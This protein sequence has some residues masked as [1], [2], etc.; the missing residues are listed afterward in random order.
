MAT[1]V[2]LTTTLE[3]SRNSVVRAEP[4]FSRLN[5]EVND[6]Q[7]F[8]L[9]LPIAGRQDFCVKGTDLAALTDPIVVPYAQITGIMA[10]LP[11]QITLSADGETTGIDVGPGPLATYLA[12]TQL[13]IVNLG[14]SAQDIELVL[15]G[16]RE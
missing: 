9:R 2:D 7:E 16:N 1:L 12:V 15:W 4:E 14:A 6:Y 13:T 11:D 5:V 8:S 3:V 10:N